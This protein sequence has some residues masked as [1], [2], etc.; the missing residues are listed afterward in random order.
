ML[1]PAR[2][3]IP[4]RTIPVLPETMLAPAEMTHP[5]PTEIDRNKKNEVARLHF[6]FAIWGTPVQNNKK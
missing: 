1:I 5:V 3:P 4:A 6:L 2:I